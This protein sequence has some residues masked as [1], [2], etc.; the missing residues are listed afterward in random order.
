[1]SDMTVSD[2]MSD[3]NFRITTRTPFKLKRPSVLIHQPN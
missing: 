1:M 3:G 2:I